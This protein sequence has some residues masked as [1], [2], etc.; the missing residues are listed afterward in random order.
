[1]PRIKF[2][3]LPAVAVL[4]VV[5]SLYYATMP[6][7]V[8]FEDAGLF[9]QVCALDGIAHPPGYPLFTSICSASTRLGGNQVILA[10]LTSITFSALSSVVVFFILLRLGARRSLC[11][12]GALFIFSAKEIWAQS[13]VVEVYSLNLLLVSLLL[14]LTIKYVDSPKTSL[15]PAIALILGLAL[16]NHWPLVV[17]SMPGILL[18][19][20]PRTQ[21]LM[22]DLKPSVLAICVLAFLLGIS[23]YVW[24]FMKSAP[25]FGYYGE[26][27]NVFD[28]VRYISRDSYSGIDNAVTADY[29]DKL[30]YVWWYLGELARQWTPIVMPI[31][32]AGFVQAVRSNPYRHCGLLAVLLGNSLLLILLLGFEFNYL[33]RSVFSAYPLFAI[34]VVGIYTVLGAE[35]ILVLLASMARKQIVVIYRVA[36]VSIVAFC[37]VDG[38]GKNDRSRDVI[39]DQYARVIL[40]SLPEDSVLII[41]A[42]SQV[43]PI[44]YMQRVEGLRKDVV[45]YSADNI[46][47]DKR[48]P[49]E[50]EARSNW[51][52]EMRANRRVF[53]I[54]VDGLTQGKD[55]GLYIEY[56]PESPGEYGSHA[57]HLPFVESRAR[58]YQAGSILQEA[59]VYFVHQ[60]LIATGHQ[61]FERIARGQAGP[62]EIAA[63]K[64]VQQ[65]FPGALAIA[66]SSIVRDG[67]KLNRALLEFVL[68]PF[69][70]NIPEVASS[71]Q[72][73]SFQKVLGLLKEEDKN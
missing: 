50:K 9:L 57:L 42:D 71:E 18:S 22:R 62:D 5:F 39:A 72:I 25:V 14:I 27:K 47:S 16:A 64:A 67:G 13:I 12:V 38:Y 70:D 36:L 2:E 3:I 43:G 56:I 21:N 34:L 37:V 10:N 55:Y 73:A 20:V 28:L 69:E 61:L 68:L 4:A 40:Q 6:V 49:I 45:I 1:M 32:V 63:L 59:D 19:M 31:A 17:A 23:P 29:S 33:F 51:V 60:M 58:E 11:F 24:M 46:F 66:T 48:M 65:T 15:L 54:Q 30:M 7:L 26:I 52:E 35:S 8:T 53:S 41:D 44:G